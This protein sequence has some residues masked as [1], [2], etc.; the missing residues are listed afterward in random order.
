MKTSKSVSFWKMGELRSVN[1]A[2]TATSLS[3]IAPMY[4]NS[5]SQSIFM[6]VRQASDGRVPSGAS[7]TPRISSKGVDH[8]TACHSALPRSPSMT[9][10]EP[11]RRG[12]T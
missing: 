2:T 10:R 9:R 6:R 5:S 3:S 4:R 12:A 11:S 8:G 7:T 1:E